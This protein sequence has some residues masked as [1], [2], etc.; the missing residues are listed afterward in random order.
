MNKKIGTYL[1]IGPLLA[2]LALLAVVLMPAGPAT[3]GTQNWTGVLNPA[4]IGSSVV[5]VVTANDGTI[6]AWGDGN[7]DGIANDIY[8]STNSGTTFT[9]I[10]GSQELYGSQELWGVTPIVEIVPSP[11]FGSDSN[12]FLAA[13]DM[14]YRSRARGTAGSWEFSGAGPS[15]A[16][17]IADLAVAADFNRSGFIAVGG[18]VDEGN[19]ELAHAV[20]C[21]TGDDSCP[22]F[23]D[24][25][26]AAANSLESGDGALAVDFSPNFQSDGTILLLAVD[27]QRDDLCID[28]VEATCEARSVSLGAVLGTG[29]SI[30]AA[31]QNAG[32]IVFPDDFNSVNVN[33]YWVATVGA[34]VTDTEVPDN[35]GSVFR[36]VQGQWTDIGGGL[37]GAL[38]SSSTSIVAD[39]NFSSANLFVGLTAVS[40]TVESQ[41]FKSAN[42][43]TFS[44]VSL[45]GGT[46]GK[47]TM[48]LSVNFADDSIVYAGT[49]GIQGGLWKSTTGGGNSLSWT[50]RGLFADDYATITD[51]GADPADANPLFIVFAGAGT[52]DDA[53]FRT[54]TQATS[55]R[56]EKV[57]RLAGLEVTAVGVSND[58]AND[59]TVYLGG[60]TQLAKSTNGG[61]SFSTAFVNAIDGTINPSVGIAVADS[62]TVYVAAGGRVHR[63]VDSGG[64]WVNTSISGSPTITALAVSP[65]HAN[66]ST[67]VVAVR[68]PAGA[69]QVWISSDGGVTFSQ[70]GSDYD[71][72]TAVG[73]AS[74]AFDS[75]YMTNQTI[76]AGSNTDIYR[77]VVG[78]S[79]SWLR[80]RAGANN[81]GA[82]P[83][84]ARGASITN[85][86]SSGGILYA[87]VAGA[88]GGVLR[89]LNPAAPWDGTA[90]QWFDLGFVGLAGVGLSQAGSGRLD[91]DGK[92]GGGFDGA[93]GAGMAVAELALNSAGLL[94]VP[95]SA[96][97][98][99]LLVVDT[100]DVD[101]TYVYSD[102]VLPAPSPSLP[103]DG[104][105]RAGAPTLQWAP[106]A[107]L[108][109][110]IF[111]V[112][113]STDPAF[114]NTV[115]TSYTKVA[116]GTFVLATG[117]LVPP[118]ASGN[119]YY[120]QVR[121]ANATDDVQSAWSP[122][123][124]YI[125]SAGVVGLLYP[126]SAPG[127]RLEVPTLTPGLS[128]TAV[129]RA[130]DYRVQIA[131]DPSVVEV[132]GSYV[133]PVITREVGS[134]TPAM[135]LGTGDLSGG[136]VY[137]WQVQAIFAGATNGAYA[138]AS[139]A[140]GASGV[141]QTAAVVGVVSVAP[142]T[143]L[144]PI[145]DNLER[146]W[147]YDNATQ[148]W[149]FY[150][151][152]PEFAAANT[153]TE[154]VNET[155]YWIKVDDTVA[156]I[157]N[158][159]QVTLF[160]GWNLVVW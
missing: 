42:G 72:S 22:P 28:P 50:S 76:Y 127:L 21:G 106:Y 26:I 138:T 60:G 27:A 117:D 45:V 58:F 84:V 77:W 9:F 70:V 67:V 159:R 136:N 158:G 65:D 147:H 16:P 154:L 57:G 78:T 35:T 90:A 39:G 148:T 152:R 149:T 143:G 130:V 17:M 48:A 137:Y 41:I 155:V 103:A 113:L 111:N 98:T 23:S 75:N 110:A 153:V 144:A 8:F 12:I 14:V 3:A 156:V 37:A 73:Q 64:N 85:L 112:R 89:I 92:S 160:A 11:R 131:L 74:I 54:T 6:F 83:T 105:S 108:G 109:G 53:L 145:A 129:A 55:S 40:G 1:K 10:D 142:A 61:L 63:T 81:A 119:T 101:N 122:V 140:A 24:G 104:S 118:F 46:A 96:T 59:N 91:Q 20:S 150:D 126:T 15:D 139:A 4:R 62:D 95:A 135:A 102:R 100:V 52:N 49:T 43:R 5:G 30:T 33:N 18:L 133:N 51:V 80:L 94:A 88:G 29:P 38:N 82:A 47:V 132:G 128:W 7:A 99:T 114:T 123:M 66:D 25:D 69:A 32:R 97:R 157:L 68:T 34:N 141:F 146:L 86:A 19:D 151:P 44:P 87:A 36:R 125:A 107:A 56:W 116:A 115:V 2:L 13:G 121:A 79:S 120:W 71:S 124:T 93:D 31:V 134:A